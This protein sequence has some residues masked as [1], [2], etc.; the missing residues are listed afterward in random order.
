MKND[1]VVDVTVEVRCEHC[2]SEDVT[3]P[4]RVG[5][6]DSIICN[7]CGADNGTRAALDE[8]IAAKAANEIEE[9]FALRLGH[10]FEGVVHV[11]AIERG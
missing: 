6:L 9:E 4:E 3:I 7:A 5:S 11:R 8:Q 10:A 1:T 2:R